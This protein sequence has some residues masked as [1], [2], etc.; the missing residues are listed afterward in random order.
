MQ[1]AQSA[2]VATT[3]QDLRHGP[4]L[5]QQGVHLSSEADPFLP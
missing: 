3:D 2:L 4:V 5:L 1:D